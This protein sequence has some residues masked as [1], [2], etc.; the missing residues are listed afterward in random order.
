[1]LLKCPTCG[2]QAAVVVK[3]KDLENFTKRGDPGESFASMGTGFGAV[4]PMVWLGLIKLLGGTLGHVWSWFSSENTR[5]IVCTQCGHYELFAK[6]SS[7]S[8]DS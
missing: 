4:P 5:Y 2:K 3:K 7:S 6:S 8:S 1:M